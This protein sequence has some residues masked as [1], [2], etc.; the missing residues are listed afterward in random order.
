MA[1]ESCDYNLL[2][3][4]QS[5][6]QATKR[7]GGLN[8]RIY[9]STV[10]SL[11]S[12]VFGT[13]NAIT[14]FTFKAGKGFVKYIGKS[15]RNASSSDVEPGPNVNIRNHTLSPVVYYETAEDLAA[16]DALIDSEGIFAVVETRA[17][18]LEVFGI[19]KVSFDS[20]GMKV[21]SNPQSS[22]VIINDDTAFLPVISG[23]HTNL[24]L[25]YNPAGTL[26]ANIIALDAQTIDGNES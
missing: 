26:A 22:G 1:D 21:T 23:G 16:L 8:K 4:I 25:L 24:Q 20:Y 13:G 14:S 11:A 3:G 7:V 2:K 17:G 10:S 5:T 12:I 6:C 9:L 19:N 18:G 15:D